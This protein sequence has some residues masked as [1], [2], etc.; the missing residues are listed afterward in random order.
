MSDK[1]ELKQTRGM[2]GKNKDQKKIL[3]SLGLGKTNKT[4][5]LEN[6]PSILGMIRRVSHLVNYKQF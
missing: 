2:A 4:V 6:T 3:K 5:I 1:I